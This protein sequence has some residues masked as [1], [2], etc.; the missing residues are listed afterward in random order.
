[1]PEEL[2]SKIH[3]GNLLESLDKA[4]RAEVLGLRCMKHPLVEAR[5][6]F[7]NLIQKTITKCGHF[8]IDQGCFVRTKLIRG[9]AQKL[10][11][12]GNLSY[13]GYVRITVAST[14][15]LQSHLVY[16][17]FTGNFLKKGE[18]IDHIDGCSFNDHPRNL[19]V[20]SN[21]INSRNSRKRTN[22]TSGYT[23][24][25]YDARCNRYYSRIT[26]NYKSIHLGYFLTSQEAYRARQD[27]IESNPELG[28]TTR[29]GL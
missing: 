26:V 18:Q 29:H 3:T 16:L 23:G 7:A 20:V 14:F 1:M 11:P 5:D 27:Y 4:T 2:L 12:M 17:W 13:N 15:F 10:G 21:T 6:Q 24:V 28:F 8:D 9:G 25:Y 19:R 22:N